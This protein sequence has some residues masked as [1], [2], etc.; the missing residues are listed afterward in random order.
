[1]SACVFDHPASPSGVGELVVEQHTGRTV[2][3][4][5]PLV[6]PADGAPML[7]IASREPVQLWTLP[8]A[9]YRQ[10]AVMSSMYLADS[11][12]WRHEAG[13]GPKADRRASEVSQVSGDQLGAA[14]ARASSQ[15]IDQ[16]TMLRLLSQVGRSQSF[17]SLSPTVLWKPNLFFVVAVLGVCT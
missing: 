12:Q 10:V 9:V 7:L 2:G 11:S 1:M 13:T 15:L 16:A 8:L 3:V 17:V 4:G 6:A 14:A 5:C